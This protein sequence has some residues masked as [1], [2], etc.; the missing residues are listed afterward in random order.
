MG[1]VRGTPLGAVI[2]GLV[3]GAVGT[4][5]MDALGYV[6]Y[7]RGGGTE[8]FR[9]WELSSG[10]TSWD[11]APAPAQVGKRLF[12]GLF[13]REI[14]PQRAALVANI[15]H[16]AYGIMGGAAYG[17]MA[18]STSRPRVWYGPV[19]GTGMWRFSYVV[20]PPTGLY[21]PLQDYDGA[22]LAKDLSVHLAYGLGTGVTL[23]LISPLRDSPL[24]EG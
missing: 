19:F 22:T 18:E 8:R 7:R 16:W 3:A 2:R 5:A 17:V 24:R 9:D 13:Q 12:E 15:T 11:D 20:L 10:L 6:E 23:R 4:A 14:P 21:K 1:L